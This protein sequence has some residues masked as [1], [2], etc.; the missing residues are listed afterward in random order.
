[1]DPISIGIT[2]AMQASGLIAGY[3]TKQFNTKLTQRAG[4]LEQQQISNNLL[5]IQNQSAQAS[6]SA[7]Q[8]LRKNMGY[9]IAAQSARGTEMAGSALALL[10]E[11]QSNTNKDEQVRQMNTLAKESDLRAAGALSGMH[12]WQAKSKLSGD[13]FDSA[14]KM[15]AADA[16]AFALE[17]NKKRK[18]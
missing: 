11:S 7:M 10:N 9:Q 8:D 15:V 14:A 13:F 18:G 2:L 17:G 3:K 16:N 5:A 6:L 1:M 12:T 4:D